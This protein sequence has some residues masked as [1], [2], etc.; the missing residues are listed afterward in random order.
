MARQHTSIR[1]DGHMKHY[2]FHVLLF[3]YTL[4][5]ISGCATTKD[6]DQKTILYVDSIVDSVTVRHS[7]IPEDTIQKLAVLEPAVPV[8][9]DFF[10]AVAIT[11]LSM[12]KYPVAQQII[13]NYVAS[14]NREPGGHCLTASKSRFLQAYKDIYGHAIYTDLPDS[15]STKFYTPSQVFDHLYASTSGMHRGW[16]SLPKKYRGK[17]NAGAIAQAGMGQLVDGDGIWKGQLRP[18][19]PMQVWKHRKDYNEVVTGINDPTIDPFGHSFIFLSYVRDVK[20]NIIG[21]K[22][23]DQG[24]QSKRTLVPNDYEVWWGVNLEI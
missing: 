20:G 10:T 2:F 24:Y 19:S 9:I 5:C 23:A 11:D 21:I 7:F 4:A 14:T 16:R 12:P 13:S 1:F 17:G 22:I 6:L 3:I 18:G 15:I 8:L